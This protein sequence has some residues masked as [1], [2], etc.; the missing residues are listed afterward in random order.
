M[1]RVRKTFHDNELVELILRKWPGKTRAEFLLPSWLLGLTDS[2]EHK[3]GQFEDHSPT[4]S[5][6]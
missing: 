3:K 2:E 4:N 6:L 1:L 5:H